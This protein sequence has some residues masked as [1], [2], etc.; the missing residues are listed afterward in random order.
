[1][2]LTLVSEFQT[3]ISEAVGP[4]RAIGLTKLPKF[5]PYTCMLDEPDV[6]PGMPITEVIPEASNEN[7]KE[8]GELNWRATENST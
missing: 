6:G 2:N 7:E 3:V 4:I 1:M 8:T 5:L